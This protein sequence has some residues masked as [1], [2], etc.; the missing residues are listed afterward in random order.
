MVDAREQLR[1][2][3]LERLVQPR[4]DLIGIAAGGQLDHARI[5]LGPARA[6]GDSRRRCATA[7]RRLERS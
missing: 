2:M 4:F 7:S 1:T 6:V 3:S 5:L